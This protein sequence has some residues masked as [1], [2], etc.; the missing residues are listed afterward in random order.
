[1]LFKV[2]AKI[3]ELFLRTFRSISIQY[4]CESFP[5]RAYPSADC[6]L[7][8]CQIDIFIPFRDKWELTAQCLNSLLQQDTPK[9]HITVHLIDNGSSPATQAK[10]NDWLTQNRSQ[11]TFVKHWIDEPFNFS[12]LCNRALT[13]SADVNRYFL[14][15]NNDVVLSDPQTLSQS[16]LFFQQNPDCGALGITLLFDNHTIQHLFAAPGVKIIAAHPFKGKTPDILKEWN[17]RARKVPAITGAYLMTRSDCFHKVA[18]FDE[19]LPTAGQD[20][21]LCLKLQ[22]QGWGNWVLPKIQATHLESASRK[23][24]PINKIEVDYI[25]DKWQEMLVK[26]PEYPAYISRWSEQPVRKL[27]EGRYPYEL[28]I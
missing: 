24:S 10:V 17:R 11:T 9:T 4:F 15:L 13:I 6:S 26:H 5:S 7:Q 23:N 21:D 28:V 27:L 25:Y 20:I 8:E 3:Y 1:V 19:N 14:F 2:C 12:K 18:G 16:A 22:Q